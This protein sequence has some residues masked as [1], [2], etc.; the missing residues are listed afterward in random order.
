MVEHAFVEALGAVG[1]P[2]LIA[3]VEQHKR[4]EQ[5]AV[6]N[7][8]PN[9]LTWLQDKRWIQTLAEPSAFGS[10]GKTAG[11]VAALQR[12]AGKS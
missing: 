6:A 3:A 10:S 5:W 12:F 4:S 9:M 7:K 11:N 1:L 2:T 8:I